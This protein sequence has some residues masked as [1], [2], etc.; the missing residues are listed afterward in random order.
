MIHKF[1]RMGYYYIGDDNVQL[2]LYLACSNLDYGSSDCT[3]VQFS[4]DWKHVTCEECL[5]CRPK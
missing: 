2:D 3:F 1:K 4:T 5:K